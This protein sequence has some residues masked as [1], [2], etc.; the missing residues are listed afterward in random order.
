MKNSGETEENGRNDRIRIVCKPGFDASGMQKFAAK[1]PRKRR[2][3]RC[4]YTATGE[5]SIEA[6]LISIIFPT[7]V[8]PRPPSSVRLLPSIAAETAHPRTVS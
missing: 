2:K 7:V 6:T 8:P 3:M 5:I 1:R 4:A